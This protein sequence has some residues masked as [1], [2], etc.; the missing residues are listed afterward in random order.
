MKTN[1]FTIT[2]TMTIDPFNDY[3]VVMADQYT[4]KL[5]AH[6]RVKRLAVAILKGKQ[7]SP[8]YVTILVREGDQYAYEGSVSNKR[9]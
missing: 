2:V 4:N 1:K 3:G 5:A 9:V 7:K 6:K 8:N